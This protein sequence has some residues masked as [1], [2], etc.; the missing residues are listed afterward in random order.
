MIKNDINSI[1]FNCMHS[2]VTNDQNLF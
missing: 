2:A 1:E